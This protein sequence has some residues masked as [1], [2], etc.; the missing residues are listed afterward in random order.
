MKRLRRLSYGPSLPPRAPPEVCSAFTLIELLVVV[1][2]IAILAALLLPALAKAQAQAWRVQ[3]VNN[4]RQLLVTWT[5]YA[6]ENRELLVLNGG[7]S[8]TVS[9]QPHLWVY[10]GNHGDPETLTNPQY[11]VG[12]NY[13]LFAPYLNSAPSYKCPADRSLWPVA[14]RN[15]LELRSYSLNSYIGSPARNVLAPLRL[16]SAYRLYQ[17]S[18][19]LALNAPADRFVFIDVNPG[20]ICTPGFGVDMGLNLIIHYPSTLHRGLGVVAFADGHAEAHKWLD[21]RTRRNLPG[22]A[23]HI[24]HTDPVAGNKD[25]KWIADHTTAKK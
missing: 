25:F 5:M 20:S 21:P 6:G 17:K 2:V 22:P 10:G 4:E 16:D 24:P 11:L 19:D 15:V 3:C 18:S 7:D 9:T 23:R 14:N 12:A 8:A 1:A 13:A